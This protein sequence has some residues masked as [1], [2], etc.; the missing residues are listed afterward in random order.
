MSSIV[1]SLDVENANAFLN[2]LLTS[3]YGCEISVYKKIFSMMLFNTYD[4]VIFSY[5]TDSDMF[6]LDFVRD[7]INSYLA[8]NDGQEMVGIWMSQ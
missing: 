7:S 8:T 5:D 6:I 1:H 4:E 3:G 2:F